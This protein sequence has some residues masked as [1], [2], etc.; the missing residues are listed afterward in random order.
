MFFYIYVFCW[1]SISF[2]F[3]DGYFCIILDHTNFS[4][5]WLRLPLSFRYHPPP[6]PFSL[7]LFVFIF[8]TKYSST[9]SYGLVPPPPPHPEGVV[10]CGCRVHSIITPFLFFSTRL[11]AWVW[12]YVYSMVSV[13]RGF[14]CLSAVGF[15][16]VYLLFVYGGFWI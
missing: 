6:P 7:S 4:T 13:C 8:V 16:I 12:I 3:L 15:V 11:S 2:I 14:V 10:H 1:Y 9:S 5:L